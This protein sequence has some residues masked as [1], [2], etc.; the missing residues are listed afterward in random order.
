MQMLQP[1]FGEPQRKIVKDWSPIDRMLANKRSSKGG[2]LRQVSRDLPPLAP[3]P[4]PAP[5]SPLPAQ[6]AVTQAGSAQTSPSWSEVLQEAVEPQQRRIRKLET[7]L[8]ASRAA[9]CASE[10]RVEAVQAKL[11]ESEA[12][13]REAFAAQSIELETLRQNLAESGEEQRRLEAD[14]QDE[15]QRWAGERAALEAEMKS[16]R[17]ALGEKDNGDLEQLRGQLELKD[18]DYEALGRRCAQ[19]QSE[20][21]SITA[22][23]N[24]LLERL[25]TEQEEMMKRVEKLERRERKPSGR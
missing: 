19:M 13:G 17:D 14:R 15:S 21:D 7:E 12:S 23:R 16:L 8:A 22:E 18:W 20:L 4:P 3:S 6:T 9:L 11:R 2:P 24:H 25:E 1:D 5:A 10:A